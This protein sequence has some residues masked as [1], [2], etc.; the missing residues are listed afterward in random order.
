MR[1]SSCDRNDDHANRFHCPRDPPCAADSVSCKQ[2]FVERE[3]PVLLVGLKRAIEV[4]RLNRRGFR[5]GVAYRKLQNSV[6]FPKCIDFLRSGPYRCVGVVRH[7]GDSTRSGHYLANCWLGGDSYA[8]FDDSRVI[9]CTWERFAAC[10]Q[11][12]YLLVYVRTRFWAGAGDGR[13]VTP[14]ARDEASLAIVEAH[15]DVAL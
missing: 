6:S 9:P 13:L 1:F 2:V 12:A 15:A 3:P 5:V 8:V 4:P 10:G 7:Q 11:E 14:Y